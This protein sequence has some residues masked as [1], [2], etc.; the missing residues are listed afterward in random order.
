M[1]PLV[2]TLVGYLP[3]LIL[4]AVMAWRYRNVHKARALR[5]GRLWILPAIYGAI[6]LAAML[7]MPTS[8]LGWLCFV[9]GVAI[10]VLLGWQRGR[11]MRLHV[12][13]DSGTVMMRQSPAA[14]VLIVVIAVLRRAIHPATPGTPPVHGHFP[15]EALYFTDALLGF[16][17]GM[18]VAQRLEIWLRAR[19]LLAEHHAQKQATPPPPPALQE[20]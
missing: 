4:I 16:V 2:R 5:P 9:A 20:G 14:L 8:G 1:S 15:A 3:I 7:S 12:D 10:G 13:D 18:I 6:V 11:L 19:A 17:L